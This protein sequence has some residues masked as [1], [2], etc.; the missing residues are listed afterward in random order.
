MCF[1]G[2]AVIEQRSTFIKWVRNSSRRK[3]KQVLQ[4]STKSTRTSLIIKKKP[5]YLQSGTNKSNLRRRVSQ[6]EQKMERSW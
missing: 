5:N 3:Q 6:N 4:N 2:E 1:E